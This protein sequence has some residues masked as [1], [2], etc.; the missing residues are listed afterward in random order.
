MSIYNG[1]GYVKKIKKVCTDKSWFP[2]CTLR[3]KERA[4]AKR[5]EWESER[6]QC[7][8]SVATL[9]SL[10]IKQT[11]ITKQAVIQH[12]STFTSKKGKKRKKTTKKKLSSLSHL[13]STQS[14]S[15]P[16]CCLIVVYLSMSSCCLLEYIKLQ[17]WKRQTMI[18][19]G[20]RATLTGQ[21]EVG[22]KE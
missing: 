3:K 16:R 7:C 17:T 9:Q 10:N 22:E 6:F 15:H 21:S 2:E 11:R 1:V 20:A 8:V 4:N 5:N 19:S 12:S 13:Y 18:H 14:H